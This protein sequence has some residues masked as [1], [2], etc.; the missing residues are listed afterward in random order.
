MS[1]AQIASVLDGKKIGSGYLCKCPAH[2]DDKHSLSVSEDNGKVL[3]KCHAGCSQDA[4]LSALKDRGLWKPSSKP[5]TPPKSIEYIYDDLNGCAALKVIRK[6]LPEGGKVIFQNHFQEGTWATGGFKGEL[7]PYRW[8]EWKDAKEVF[9]CEGEKCANVLWEKGICGT[10]TPGGAAGWKSLFAQSFERK[11]VTILPDHDGPGMKYARSALADIV[12]VAESVKIVEL[13]GLAEKQDVF[14]WFAMGHSATDLLA[15]VAKQGESAPIP[16]RQ[17]KCERLSN[18]EAKK[19]DWIWLNRIPK[20]TVTNVEG[21]GGEGK[22]MIMADICSRLSNG[23]RLPDDETDRPPHKILLLS[24]EDDPGAVL[25]PRFDAHG[26]NL[27]NILFDDQAMILNAEG[28]DALRSAIERHLIDLIVIDPI[29][30]FLGQKL[31]MNSGNDVRSVLQPLIQMGR[32]LGC[33]FV[34]VRHFNK[35]KEGAANQRGAG[36]VDFRNAAR[37]TLQVIKGEDRNWLAMDKTNY[38]VKAKSVAFTIEQVNGVGKIAWGEI[39][40]KTADQLHGESHAAVV[41]QSALDE[42]IEFLENELKDGPR[43]AGEVS[44]N[45]RDLGIKDATLRRAKEKAGVKTE[46]IKGSWHCRWIEVDLDHA[47]RGVGDEQDQVG[48]VTF[49][50]DLSDRV[51]EVPA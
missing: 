51:R 19:M 23:T 26:A 2:V 17:L 16:K 9:L 49:S 5:T 34:I 6:D 20:G 3:V 29:V 1:A 32:D 27:E 41:G 4:V 42:A 50:R 44:R 46:K 45:A 25:R 12:K 30:S 40:D 28:L 15:E 13:P 24:A 31:D 43:P 21:N 35:G 37:A 47:H 18:V 22:S 7:R 8:K 10:T 39:S 11:C 36:S 48:L 38:G 33:T 14:D